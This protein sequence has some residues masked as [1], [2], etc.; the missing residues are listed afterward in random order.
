MK[1]LYKKRILF[2]LT[3][4]T[5][6]SNIINA[7]NYT[8]RQLNYL[9]Q[10]PFSIL[11]IYIKMFSVAIAC[12]FIGPVRGMTNGDKSDISR[13]LPVYVPNIV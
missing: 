12:P 1:L 5:R 9:P 13:G 8:D 4:L 3:F 6:I 11:M 10:I 7:Q 2:S